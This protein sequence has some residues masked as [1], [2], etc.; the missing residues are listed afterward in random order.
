VGV[1]DFT[2]PT[3]VVHQDI[4]YAKGCPIVCKRCDLLLADGTRKTVVVD[5]VVKV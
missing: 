4:V 2:S 3:N 1:K 5:G